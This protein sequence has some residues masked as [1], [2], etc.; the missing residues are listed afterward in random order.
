MTGA[1]GA[2]GADRV[3]VTLH[4]K[5]AAELLGFF[6]FGAFGAFGAISFDKT[7]GNTHNR[8]A[9][10]TWHGAGVSRSLSKGYCTI[11]P[12]APNGVDAP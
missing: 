10:N 4:Q 2:I 11:A 7:P 9:S 8:L 5:K 3:A 1:I 12:S 6:P